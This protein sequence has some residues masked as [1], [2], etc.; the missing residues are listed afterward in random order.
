MDEELKVSAFGT[1]GRLWRNMKGRYTCV[2]C[3]KEFEGSRP[4]YADTLEQVTG[5]LCDDCRRKIDDEYRRKKSDEWT[6]REASIALEEA[7]VPS[8]MSDARFEDWTSLSKE[9]GEALCIAREFC[10]SDVTR[11]LAFIGPT[12][13]GKTHLAVS[14]MRAMRKRNPAMTMCYI[15]E[16]RF[17]SA[18]KGTFDRGVRL[19]EMDVV[20]R[21]LEYDL[22]VIDEIGRSPSQDYMQ[23]R[24][25]IFLQDRMEDPRKRTVLA[26]N[27][28]PGRFREIVGD[29]VLSR[30]MER[31]QDGKRRAVSVKLDGEDY[32]AIGPKERK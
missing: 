9:H 1:E 2:D 4:V 29:A 7:G 16:D 5:V 32:R 27:V 18:L 25:Q 15:T 23:S 24:F 30:L 14:I 31:T 11:T 12:G 22:L 21:F 19:S 13:R 10:T 28:T 8:L 17:Y 3:G 20:D 6:K 26:G